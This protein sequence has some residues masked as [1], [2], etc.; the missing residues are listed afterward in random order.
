MKTLLKIL[1]LLSILLPFR[2]SAGTSIFGFGPQLIGSYQYPYST[3][4]L[5]R[6]GSE[7]SFVDS[8]GINYMNYALWTKFERTTVSIGLTYTGISTK[9]AFA[10]TSSSD[11]NFRGGFVAVPLKQKKL[12]FGFGLMPVYTNSFG[13][14]LDN[15]G[16]DNA[17]TQKIEAKGNITE[18]LLLFGIALSDRLALALDGGYDFGIIIDKISVLYN[19]QAYSDI[20]VS[21]EFQSRG[22]NIGLSAFYEMTDRFSM[23]I[24]YK[25][26]T[27]CSVNTE[28][29]SSNLPETQ[30][31]T[32]TVVYPALS[33]LG[34]N[35]KLKQHWQI[36]LDFIYQD[37]EKSYRIDDEKSKRIS[38]S[39]RFGLGVEK[40]PGDRRFVPYLQDIS[41]RGGFFF[42]QL[43]VKI[44]NNPVM[45]YGVTG[46]VSLPIRKNR[47]RIDISFEYG[48]RE[49]TG[50]TF[51]Q[52]KLLKINFALLNSEVWFSREKR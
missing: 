4:A 16:P 8:L 6:G 44:E 49:N 17:V 46:G 27:H 19:D 41:W 37:W 39:Y 3:S 21:D 50:S 51:L 1:P 47:T 42:S 7:M 34:L 29:T 43:N 30:K 33:A 20:T 35:Y 52:E 32:K 11:A 31:G 18:A 23:G 24:K 13:V 40:S 12:V 48:I 2:V 10:S 28:R 38:D 36:G 25:S 9:S 15:R 14:Q 26:R 45:E 5:G 22:V